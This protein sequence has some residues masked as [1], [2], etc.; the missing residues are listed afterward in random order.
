MGAPLADALGAPLLPLVVRKLPV[1]ISPEMGFGAVAIDGSLVLNDRLVGELGL[2]RDRIDS[3]AADVREEV[4]RRAREYM[5][6]D[7]IPDVLGRDVF[8]IDD[9]LA[10]GY[11]VIAAARMVKDLAPRSLILG[12]PVSPEGSLR[13]VAPYFDEAYCLIA[14]EYPPFAVAS[15][16]QDFHDMSDDEVRRIL[17]RA[18]HDGKD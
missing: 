9:G 3:I 16:Y 2:S 1:P 17:K 13:T 5:G 15:F 4:E 12:V 11:S 14:Q 6:D 7:F 10:T 18:N 8:L